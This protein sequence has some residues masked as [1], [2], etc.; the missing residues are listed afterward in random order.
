MSCLV[1]SCLRARFGPLI[2]ETHFLRDET[3][4]EGS[5]FFLG[6]RAMQQLFRHL[7]A[8]FSTFREPRQPSISQPPAG[9]GL[10]STLDLMVTVMK[11]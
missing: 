7:P 8:L 6:P 2:C 10:G 9:T 5:R 1:F 11:E 3:D 4:W